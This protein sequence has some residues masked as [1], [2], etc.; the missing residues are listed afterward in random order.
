[1]IRRWSYLK[2]DCIELTPNNSSFTNVYFRKTF[3]STVR[4]K[5]FSKVL[6]KLSRKKYN[7]RKI[8]HSNYNLL[9]YTFSWIKFYSQYISL[10]KLTQLS[11]M[12]FLNKTSA[13]IF[14][15]NKSNAIILSKNLGLSFVSLFISNKQAPQSLIFDKHFIYLD[16]S[17]KHTIINN[18]SLI[19]ISKQKSHVFLFNKLL[20]RIFVVSIL[21]N[22]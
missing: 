8:N 15:Q 22:F 2:N 16:K 13:P 9:S 20:R 3:K 1:M 4:F 11:S 14:N 7:L 19:N 18:F 12:Y 21:K 10:N 5:R 6:S 17:K